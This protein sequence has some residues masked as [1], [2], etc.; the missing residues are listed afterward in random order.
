MRVWVGVGSC[1][2]EILTRNYKEHE[3]QKIGSLV[4][5]VETANDEE[6]MTESA[7]DLVLVQRNQ[8]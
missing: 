5:I 2:C 6:A 4:E 8:A 3:K 1:V 7:L